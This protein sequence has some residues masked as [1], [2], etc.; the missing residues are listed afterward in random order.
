MVEF[1]LAFLCIYLILWLPNPNGGPE[2][3]RISKKFRIMRINHMYENSMA[4]FLFTAPLHHLQP[5]QH[6]L[7]LTHQQQ[8]PE[9]PGYQ[10]RQ[11]IQLH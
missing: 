4:G 10:L 6:Y 5:R 9:L 8:L 1:F 3:Q 11:H 7:Q 2:I